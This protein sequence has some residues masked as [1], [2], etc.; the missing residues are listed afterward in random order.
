MQKGNYMRHYYKHAL[1]SQSHWVLSYRRNQGQ[2]IRT[3]QQ[4]HQKVSVED[5]L[6]I[7]GEVLSP[8]V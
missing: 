1:I 3:N 7:S 4:G 5:S 8:S 6:L 2:V